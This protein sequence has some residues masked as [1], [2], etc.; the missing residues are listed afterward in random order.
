[1]K[2]VVITTPGDADVLQIQDVDDPQLNDDEVLIK[3][4]AAGL[5]RSD[6]S[7]RLGQYPPPKGARP[8][9][10]VECSGVIEAVGKDVQKWEVGDEVCA[11]LGG[12]GYAEKV[13]VHS[14]HVLPI[15]KGISLQEAA[16]LPEVACTVWSTVFMTSHLS[17]G[18]NFLVHGG[19]SGIGTFAIQIAKYCGA[20]VFVT[21]G[22]K[23]KLA[24]C[25]EL[26]ADVAINYKTEDFVERV[27]EE[28]G[29]KGVDVILDN[30]GGP[31]LQRNLD[32]LGLDGR[33]FVIGFQGGFITEI[34]L[35]T[36]FGKRLTIQAAGLRTRS[37]ENKEQIIA[38]VQKHIWPAFEEGKVKPIIHTT[39]PLSQAAE[40]HR[41]MESNTHTGKILL[42][43]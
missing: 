28:T 10:G 26:G 8:Y 25:K 32:A 21:A 31:Y 41:I 43:V 42:I 34:N 14:G 3:V 17:L 36:I 11:L 23:E 35:S 30:M 37:V 19:S 20:R 38:D 29:G 6:I 24:R 7:Q 39:L 5:N 18:E 15:P 12:G 9:P 33:L 16:A 22:S 4:S 2:A 27:K 40:A 13:A 1:M